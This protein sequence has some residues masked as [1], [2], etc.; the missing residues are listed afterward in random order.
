[1]G[2]LIPEEEE[3]DD[4]DAPL[5]IILGG[6]PVGQP[7]CTVKKDTAGRLEGGE[8]FMVTL[9]TTDFTEGGDSQIGLPDFGRCNWSS[10]RRRFSYGDAAIPPVHFSFSSI[11]EVSSDESYIDEQSLSS[12]IECSRGFGKTNCGRTN[13]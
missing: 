7:D 5:G 2:Q 4:L 3:D 12:T 9:E 13:N 10:R 8:L 6:L 11:I 1:M